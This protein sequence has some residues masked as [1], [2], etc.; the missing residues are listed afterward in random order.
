M[1]S[2]SRE[3][4]SDSRAE[5]IAVAED[6]AAPYIDLHQASIDYVE[7]IGED[8]AHRLNREPDD[9]TRK[10]GF[11]TVGPCSPAI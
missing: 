10:S 7:A 1:R 6:Q 11:A 2:C 5:T 8:A 3:R 9:N 4:A